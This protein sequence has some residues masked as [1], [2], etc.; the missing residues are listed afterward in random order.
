MSDFYGVLCLVL[1]VGVLIVAYM[2]SQESYKK[3]EAARLAYLAS[4]EELKANPNNPDLKQKT[5]G[6]GRSYSNLT[7]NKSGATLF[8]EV[9][10]MNDINAATAAANSVSQPA[11]ALATAPA[12]ASVEE[13]L[14]K[15]TSLKT[16][17]MITEDE[18]NAKRQKIMDEI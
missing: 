18:Y 1:V 4:L 17:G 16:Q 10:L 6:L 15:L 13:R 2:S 12:S 8:D 11:L 14:A 5:L 9:A 3:R 7:R